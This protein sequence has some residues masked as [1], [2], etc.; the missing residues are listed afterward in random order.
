MKRDD[1]ALIVTMV[2]ETGIGEEIAKALVTLK[3][4]AC[5]NIIGGATSCYRWE[6]KLQKDSEALLMVKTRTKLVPRV[7]EAIEDIHPYELPE[8]IVLPIAGGSE[9]YLNW[10]V[11]ETV[12]QPKEC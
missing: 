11:N 6:G 5:V 10:V 1:L 8:M 3:L 4:A 7:Q 12:N 2:P 9:R